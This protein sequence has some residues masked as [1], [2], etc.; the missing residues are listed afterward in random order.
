[1]KRRVLLVVL[2]CSLGLAS[3]QSPVSKLTRVDLYGHVYVRLEEWAWANNFQ[4]KRPRNSEW[5]QVTNRWARLQFEV[6]SRKAEIDGVK[7]YLSVPVAARNGTAYIAPVD[8]RTVIHPVLFPPKNNPEH[9]IRTVCLDPGHGGNDPG[10][11]E[12]PWQEK[13]YTLLLAQEVRSLLS[14]SDIKVVLTRTTD[15][16]VELPAR[17]DVARRKGA[18]LFVSLHFNSFAGGARDARGVEV[19]CLT[20]AGASSSNARGEGASSG[21]YPGNRQNEKN[22]LLAYQ[23]QKSLTRDL[24]VEDR[25][26]RRARFSVMRT[27]EMPAVLIEGG[28]MSHPEE[29][30]K[31][32]DPA[33]LHK[34]AQAIVDG[35]LAYKRLVER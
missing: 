2:F 1:M 28:Y 13:K 16:F 5:L 27:A 20:P 33:Y 24:Q 18:D 3:G 9:R 35:I 26:V 17:P 14:E 4:V 19:Y 10:N 31:I 8:L 30:R 32:T 22:M 7:V 12:G 15:T 21:A 29:G 11:Q 25:G 6:D 34:M 23:L